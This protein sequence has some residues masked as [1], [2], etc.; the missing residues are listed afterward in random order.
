[1]IITLTGENAFALQQE[2]RKLVGGFLAEHG[3]MGLERLDGEE[4]EYVRMQEALTSLPFLANKKM[5]VLRAPS[6]NKKFVEEAEKLLNEVPETTDVVIVEPKLD[7]RLSYYKHLK[8]AT[9][10]HEFSQMDT[11]GLAAW[12]QRAAKEQGGALSSNDARYLI[13]RVGANQQLLANELEKLLIHDFKITRASIDELTETTPQSTIFQLLE[14][15]FAG[16]TKRALQ[17]YQEQ[18]ALKVEPHQIT[19]MLTWQLHV[20]AIIKTAGD[21]S[22]AEIAKEAR[23]SPFVVQKSVNIAR[24]MS[25]GELKKLIADLLNIDIRS[26]RENIDTDEALQ[27]YILSMSI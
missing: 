16:N 14:A 3:D 22:P 24:K 12:L 7:K 25:M 26:K 27:H 19:A 1:M 23:L 6:A 10:F 11:N 17:L 8:K 9:A 4:A 2:L 18:R 5:V 13:E 15:A 20:L 21:L